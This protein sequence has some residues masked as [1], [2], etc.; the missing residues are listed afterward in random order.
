MADAAQ[1]EAIETAEDV[2]V[3]LSTLPPTGLVTVAVKVVEPPTALDAD[4]GA[5]LTVHDLAGV[6]VGVLVLVGVGAAGVGVLVR[7]GVG[8][9]GV[10][11]RVRVGVGGG[12]VGVG[13][14]TDKVEKSEQ[15]L[16]TPPIDTWAVML[17]LPAA[18]P[19]APTV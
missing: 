13:T 16:E 12:G 2:K 17:A 19:V 10:G 9:A 5:I 3:T 1:T 4:T 18:L 6:G 8:G 7:V 11:V 15:M 14:A